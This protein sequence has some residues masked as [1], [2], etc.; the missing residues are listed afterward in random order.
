VLKLINPDPLFLV[1]KNFGYEGIIPL[2][3]IQ[4]G[5][6]EMKKNVLGIAFSLLFLIFNSCSDDSGQLSP[7]AS[8]GDVPDILGTYVLNGTDYLGNDYGGHLTITAGTNPGEYKFQWIIMESVQ[9]GTGYLEGNQ[10]QVQWQ[11]I[12]PSIALYQGSVQYTVTVNGE[13]YGTRT[14]LGRDGT[15]VETAYPNQ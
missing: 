8:V 5:A 9:I 10:I 6:L 3:S 7:D 2:T 1:R 14:I 4:F 12:D 11:S 13:L 15:G